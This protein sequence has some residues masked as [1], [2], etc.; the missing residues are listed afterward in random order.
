MNNVL[1]QALV[2]QQ[3]RK[4]APFFKNILQ[5]KELFNIREEKKYILLVSIFELSRMIMLYCGEV[6][7]K[8]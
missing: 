1:N 7:Y 6:R 5:N 2:L 4:T 3:Q 8:L